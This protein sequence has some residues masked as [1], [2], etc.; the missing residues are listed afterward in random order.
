MLIKVIITGDTHYSIVV[1]SSDP[2]FITTWVDVII[3]PL[4]V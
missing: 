2:G 1:K 3:L 4:T